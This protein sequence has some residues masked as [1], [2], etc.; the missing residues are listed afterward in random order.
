MFRK[1]L[2]IAWKDIY[3]A[4]RDR[5]AML[6]MFAMP[7][8]L[9][10]IIGLAFGT[11]GDISISAVPVGVVNHDTG[12]EVPGGETI[13]FGQ[14]LE[15]AFVP[16]G[17]PAVDSDY[18][19]IHDL[20]DGEALGASDTARDHVEDG[21]LAAAILIGE[22]FSSRALMGAQPGT[23][24]IYYD[25]ARSVGP[26]VVRSIVNAITNGMNSVILAQRLGPPAIRRIGGEIDADP[27]AV[28]A[29]A[30][31]IMQD[32]TTIAQSA[33][34]R[35]EQQDLQGETRT[36]DALQYFAPSMAILFMTFA[37]ASGA[38]SILEES[39]DWTL[40][41]IITTPTPRWAFMGGK[42]AGMYAIGVIQM[43]VLVVGT[44][45]IALLMG[46]EEPVWGT[47]IPGI[48]L[49][50]LAVV[51]TAT[52]LGL[53]IAAL[54]RTP[55][56]AST[57]STAALF[58]LGMLGGSFIPIDNLPDLIGWLPKIT[59]NYWGIQGFFALAYENAPIGDILTNLL[60]L[61]AMGVVL[62]VASLW[63]FNRRPDLGA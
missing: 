19:P 21:D 5:N 50:V 58:V 12:A 63:R 33:P 8:V 9:S 49:L 28:E 37:M 14:M 27:A 1:L 52:S 59:L 56:Q 26:S 15:R 4:F 35:L 47:N 55:G 22:S 23:V 24:T 45:L 10:V 38:T 34:I 54:S 57:Y 11:G 13:N 62:F 20:T 16:A 25:S 51:F 18:A 6:I 3:V 7:V 43:A 42:L 60:V 46:R 48:V 40:Q 17:D 61:V 41:R 30:G 53:L 2:A 29:A 36:F 32:A 39:R 31:R 44:S